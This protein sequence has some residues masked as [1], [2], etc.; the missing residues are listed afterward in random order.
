MRRCL[1]WEFV[2]GLLT[3]GYISRT[4]TE[5]RIWPWAPYL[6]D[7]SYGVKKRGPIAA[8]FSVGW[9]SLAGTDVLVEL[10]FGLPKNLFGRSIDGPVKELNRRRL[11]SDDFLVREVAQRS[12]R[13]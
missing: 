3:S 6:N 13:Q 5:L 9:L 12:T 11:C 4:L 8:L 10:M 7:V 1:V 2:L